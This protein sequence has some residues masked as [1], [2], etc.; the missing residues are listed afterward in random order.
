MHNGISGVGDGRE[1][2]GLFGAAGGF[3]KS[4]G[5]V[6]LGQTDEV[7]RVLEG[8]G[9]ETSY[10]EVLVHDALVTFE[11]EVQNYDGV[12]CRIRPPSFELTCE[13]LGEDRVC[14]S[15]EVEVK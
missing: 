7:A 13:H 10:G 8:S 14:R 12:S 15:T 6:D 5:V 1:Y 4:L 2:V 3:G 9:D 11:T